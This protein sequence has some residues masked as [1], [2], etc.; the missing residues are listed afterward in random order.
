M[1]RKQCALTGVSI[2]FRY[3]N[4][5]AQEQIWDYQFVWQLNASLDV[6]IKWSYI[7]KIDVAVYR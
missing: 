6:N 3:S 2:W 5:E 7:L 4:A 1:L